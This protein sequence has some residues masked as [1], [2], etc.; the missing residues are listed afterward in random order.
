MKTGI[1]E[2]ETSSGEVLTL[3]EVL[4]SATYRGLLEGRPTPD[5]NQVILHSTDIAAEKFWPGLGAVTLDLPTL[6][7]A[8]CLPAYRL[9][10]LFGLTPPNHRLNGV[11]VVWFQD[12]LEPILSARTENF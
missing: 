5:V 12:E 2:L 6:L 8:E 3:E 9:T 1:L 11:V 10:G 7:G 4:V